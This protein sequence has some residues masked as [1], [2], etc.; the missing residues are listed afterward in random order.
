MHPG[1]VITRQYP[2]NKDE[3]QLP[4]RFRG[5]VVLIHNEEN[6]HWC[7]GCTACE[8][9]CPNGSIKII[10]RRE[11]TPEGKKKKR[12]YQF[13]YYLSMCT[14]CNLCIEACPTAAIRMGQKFDHSVYDR[15]ELN[16]VLNKEHSTLVKE[17]Q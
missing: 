9:A 1:K 17:L 12:L 5:E 13:D 16:K 10:T 2:E 6:E 4:G 15:Q 7:T 14:F 11:E 3:L 8:I